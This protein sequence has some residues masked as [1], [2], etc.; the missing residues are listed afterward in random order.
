ML[1]VKFQKKTIIS[2]STLYCNVYRGELTIR[3]IIV[4]SIYNNN[5]AQ[6]KEVLKLL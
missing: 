1:F 5:I 3:L 2:M 4:P 6:K